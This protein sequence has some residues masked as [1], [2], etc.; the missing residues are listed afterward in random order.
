MQ[1]FVQDPI[2]QLP[3]LNRIDVG[4][5]CGLVERARQKSIMRVPGAMTSQRKTCTR[6]LEP[7][8]QTAYCNGICLCHLPSRR[9]YGVD[10]KLYIKNGMMIS[11]TDM[12]YCNVYHLLPAMGV[13]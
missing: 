11:D 2:E 9:A 6:F 13:P 10:I 3:N 5:R 7:L 4:Q 1:C 8:P 12:V